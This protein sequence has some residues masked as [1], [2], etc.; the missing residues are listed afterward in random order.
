MKAQL[1]GLLVAIDL[2]CCAPGTAQL[3]TIEPDNYATGTVLDHIVPEVHLTTAGANNQPIPPVPFPVTSQPT[4][5]GYPSTGVNV[6]AQAG[7]NFFWDAVRLRMDFNGLVQSISLDSIGSGFNLAPERG[8][9]DVY[10]SENILID[11]YTTG[12]LGAGQVQ[13]MSLSHADPDMAW[14]VA[15]SEGQTFGR[16]DHLV[17]S[18]PVPVPEPAMALL[19]GAGV[20]GIFLFGARRAKP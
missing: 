5:P 17:F 4:P 7:V 2:V 11:S 10:N 12:V 14:A 19:F 6:F 3:I 15:W 13:T 18:T 20:V 8:H 1:L 9:L 16:L